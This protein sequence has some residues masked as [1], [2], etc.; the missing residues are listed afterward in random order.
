MTLLGPRGRGVI[1]LGLL[2]ALVTVACALAIYTERHALAGWMPAVVGETA[3]RSSV[4]G[5][6]LGAALA[7]WLTVPLNTRHHRWLSLIHI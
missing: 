5:M 7:A 3:M 2:T 1:P 4:L 6:V